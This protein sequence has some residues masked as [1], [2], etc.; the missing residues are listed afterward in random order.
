MVFNLLASENQ[1]ALKTGRDVFNYLGPLLHWITTPTG[2]IALA[3]IA[4]GG[5]LLPVWQARRG[6]D[7]FCG[8]SH[9]NGRVFS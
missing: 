7:A 6:T 8:I 1:T 9:G 4:V 2:V 3:F 5:V